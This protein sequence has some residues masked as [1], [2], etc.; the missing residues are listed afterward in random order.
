MDRLFVHTKLARW[1]RQETSKIIR[2]LASQVENYG[3]VTFQVEYRETPAF[4]RSRTNIIWAL[5][6]RG[7]VPEL[8]TSTLTRLI[9]GTKRRRCRRQYIMKTAA[10]VEPC[11]DTGWSFVY[12]H[13]AIFRAILLATRPNHEP[14][15][16]KAIT[17][18]HVMPTEGFIR[19][20]LEL[21]ES[22]QPEGR[23]S[24]QSRITS[25]DNETY[26]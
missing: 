23:L 26:A 15:I 3:I 1:C 10:Q 13:P 22:S 8:S 19:I 21:D 17:N 14:P 5:Q 4:P 6:I 11:W 25:S 20:R 16:G 9:R 2:R 12:M 7:V 18:A 24:Q